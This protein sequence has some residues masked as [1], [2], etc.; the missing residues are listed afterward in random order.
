[1]IFRRLLPCLG[2]FA[3][4]GAPAA[5]GQQ[6]SAQKPSVRGAGPITLACETPLALM[7]G[8]FSLGRMPLRPGVPFSD[9]A[10]PCRL[11][12]PEERLRLTGTDRWGGTNG[13]IMF[14]VVDERGRTYWVLEKTLLEC[15]LMRALGKGPVPLLGCE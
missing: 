12:F 10:I 3:A 2:I 5:C 1:M 9:R 14:S 8:A 11:I 13:Q 6:L 7:Q 15:D 4:L